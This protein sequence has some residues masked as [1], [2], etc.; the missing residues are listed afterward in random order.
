MDHKSRP[1]SQKSVV[2]K[3]LRTTEVIFTKMNT[4]D[5]TKK[6]VKC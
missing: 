3:G 4:K 5:I 2:L 6:V 1:K